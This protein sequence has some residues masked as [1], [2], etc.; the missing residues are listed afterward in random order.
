M[1][2]TLNFYPKYPKF[3]MPY[4]LIH[5]S[6]KKTHLIYHW[7]ILQLTDVSGLHNNGL[8]QCIVIDEKSHKVKSDA[9]KLEV[10]EEEDMLPPILPL[11]LPL[12]SSPPKSDHSFST[13]LQPSSSR[14]PYF[15]FTSPDRQLSPGSSTLLKC[16]AGGSPLPHLTWRLN[17][18]VVKVKISHDLCCSPEI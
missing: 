4:Q 16:I 17:G 14:L 3:Q 6:L 10:L 8:Y 13:L 7:Q 15:I 1:P 12:I 2:L 5:F 18:R 9:A 11:A